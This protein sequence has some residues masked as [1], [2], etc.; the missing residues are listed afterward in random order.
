VTEQIERELAEMFHQR[1][2]QLDVL[3]PRPA[4]Q[5]RR[6]RLQA[7]LALASVVAVVAGAALAA[8]KVA[9]GSTADRAVSIAASGA[10]AKADLVDA[11]KRTLTA[12]EV[13]TTRD[14]VVP[15]GRYLD[16]PDL[17]FSAGVPGAHPTETKYDGRAGDAVT[18]R[19]GQVNMVLVHDALYRRLDARD[20]RIALPPGVR[21]VS[22]PQDAG[23]TP[24]EWRQSSI[25]F[26]IPGLF[27]IY[28]VPDTMRTT[29]TEHDGQFRMTVSSAGQ[30]SFITIVQLDGSGLIASVTSRIALPP[31]SGHSDSV[32][33]VTFQP[34]SGPV[35]ATAPA[36]DTVMTGA[37]YDRARQAYAQSHRTCA[38]TRPSTGPDGMQGQD[39][40]CSD[41]SGSASGSL[42]VT[43]MTTVTQSPLQVVVVPVPT[44]TPR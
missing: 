37:D 44:G 30:A 32:D 8:A 13:A 38:T 22:Y 24:R 7:G 2:E 36:A 33:Q 19:D 23:E 5:V 12:K 34:L 25:A 39:V 27:A 26:T 43:P 1:A 11:F 10:R 40:T 42:S 16:Q 14:V 9:G 31:L 17:G 41:G 3:P 4:A 28:A 6:A 18:I 20:S 35:G 21:W 15:N 29:V